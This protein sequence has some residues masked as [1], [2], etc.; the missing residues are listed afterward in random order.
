MASRRLQGI[1]ETSAR[2]SYLHEHAVGGTR[3]R[4]FNEL[5]LVRA[6]IPVLS[7]SWTL[8]HKI[9]EDSPLWG[10]TAERL[11]AEA[12]TLMVSVSGFDEAISSTINDRK[13]YRAANVRVGHVFADILRDLP[14]GFIEL[15]LTRI[16]DTVP[17]SGATDLSAALDAL[18]A[19]A[20]QAATAGDGV[21]Q[22]DR[23][24]AS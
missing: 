17:L 23:V 21:G 13:T 9:D 22:D 20:V 10:M 2:I 16:H 24:S 8:I 12:P 7:L 19:D 6:N 3:F 4:R 18:V 1:S 11:E 5:K 15:D 14:G